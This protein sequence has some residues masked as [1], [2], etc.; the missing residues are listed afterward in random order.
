MQ[1]SNIDYAFLSAGLFFKHWLNTLD[2][3]RWIEASRTT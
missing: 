3:K 1:L 2:G